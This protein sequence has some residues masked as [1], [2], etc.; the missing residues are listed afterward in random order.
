MGALAT[1]SAGIKPRHL[2]RDA[3]FVQIDQRFRAVGP[4]ALLPISST[5]SGGFGESGAFVSLY[6]ESQRF[7]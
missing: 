5:A 4:L 3:A 7:S 2:R 1:W 6:I